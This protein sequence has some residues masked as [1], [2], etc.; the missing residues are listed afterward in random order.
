M[1]KPM[2][3]VYIPIQ[4][5]QGTMDHGEMINSMETVWK[6][7]QMVL[8]M[9]VN[10]QKAKRMEKASLCLQMVLFMMVSFK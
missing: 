4:M 5:G 8:F 2:E 9:R 10:I 3:L 7:G 6:S 1:I